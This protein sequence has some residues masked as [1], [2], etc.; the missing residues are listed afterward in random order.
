[1]PSA[2]EPPTPAERVPSGA[3]QRYGAIVAWT[4]VAYL[5]IAAAGRLAYAIPRLVRDIET[6][7]ALDL[8]YR[9]GE[10]AQWFAGAPVYGVVDGAVYPPASHVILWP[11][12]G[13]TSLAGARVVWAVTILAAALALAVLAWRLCAPAAARERLLIAGLAFAAYPLQQSVFVGQLGVHVVAFAAW[14]AY[15]CVTGRPR[16]AADLAAGVL[17]AA[18]L[19]KP[20]LSL[21]LV[22][23]ALIAAGRL[24]PA[25][26]T[27]G[28][29]AA[30]TLVA[31]AA[32]PDGVVRLFREWL[33]IA[34]QRV[35]FA[36][37]V[38]NLHML[39]AAAGLHDWM[40]PASLALLAA[41]AGWMVARRH[42]DPWLLMGV[43]GIVA[44]VWA[45]STTYDDAFLLLPVVALFR[46]LPRTTGGMRQ[47]AVALL[48]L[49]WAS[50]LTPTWAYYDLG[51]AAVWTIHGLQTVLWL[52]VLAFLVTAAGR[53]PLGRSP[54]RS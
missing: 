10:V 3:W 25:V 13:W 31:A 51:P 48:V 15:L 21:P 53:S 47:V 26:L 9:Y 29:Y 6:W 5:A 45:H 46:T 22:A 4:G 1:M 54:A 40:T 37:G 42:A 2:S 34:G 7:S 23:A 8:K 41:M 19:V 52:A 17:L 39:L 16:V 24:R 14:G 33:A 38:P 43:A 27:G 49:A 11:F 12:L 32:Q 20:T 35:P 50:M 44:R 18:S 28:A 36:D 30:L